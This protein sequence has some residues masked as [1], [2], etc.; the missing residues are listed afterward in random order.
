[1]QRAQLVMDFNPISPAI[2]PLICYVLSFATNLPIT[3]TTP[4]ACT[5]PITL[6]SGEASSS[7]S[8]YL[9]PPLVAC[10]VASKTGKQTAECR[11]SMPLCSST[12]PTILGHY[13]AL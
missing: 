12:A 1:M 8:A 4:P 5:L 2:T 11:K 10:T 3:T 7:A 6:T 9:P 13:Y